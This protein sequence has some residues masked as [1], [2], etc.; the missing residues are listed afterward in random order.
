MS[1]IPNPA[2][3]VLESARAPVVGSS[4]LCPGCG[5]ALKDRQGACSG[6]C[7]A[8]LSRQRREAARA[9]RHERTRRLLREALRVLEE[10]P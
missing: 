8:S 6:K 3:D 9:E 4:R 10:S 1:A 2:P 7:R 5:T